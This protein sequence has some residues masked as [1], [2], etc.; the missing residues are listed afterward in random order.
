MS[1]LEGRPKD[2]PRMGF[3][4]RQTR[5]T[6]HARHT[7]RG[8]GSVADGDPPGRLLLV[9]PAPLRDAGTGGPRLLRARELLPRAGVLHPSSLLSGA[10]SRACAWACRLSTYS[11]RLAAN[12]GLLPMRVLKR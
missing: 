2:E 1:S 4:R 8:L 11:C 3:P 7:T 9:V 12:A 10:R 5:R 6:R